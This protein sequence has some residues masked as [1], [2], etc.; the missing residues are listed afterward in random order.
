MMWWILKQKR[1]RLPRSIWSNHSFVQVIASATAGRSAP[2]FF[3]LKKQR[4]KTA[5]AK[6]AAQ[7]E[8]AE[9][10]PAAQRETAEKSSLH[11]HL[12]FNRTTLQLQQILRLFVAGLRRQLK[13][14]QS[15]F[16]VFFGT[17]AGIIA[18]GQFAQGARIIF[19][20]GG[21]QPF[22]G[23]FCVGRHADALQKSHSEFKLT[24]GVAKLGGLRIIKRGAHRIQ[25]HADA[26]GVTA[27]EL[28]QSVRVAIVGGL[29][30]KSDALGHVG[31]KY[32]S[33]QQSVA[34]FGQPS[35]EPRSAANL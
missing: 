12:L 26:V 13:A 18:P 30:Q 4:P 33:D 9:A 28:V 11:A 2:Q 25:L 19:I 31:R 14:I 10:K 17:D 16:R 1:W 15:F 23:A 35:M 34:D 32:V 24:I 6:P 27:A 22:E 7:R 5:E 8:T 21:G 29:A 3:I 20:G